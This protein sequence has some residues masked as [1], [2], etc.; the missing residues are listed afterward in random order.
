MSTGRSALMSSCGQY[1]YSLTRNWSD[2]PRVGWVLLNPSTADG[3]KDDPTVRRVI[4]F[5]H[6]WGY[7]GLV[8]ANLYAYRATK[9]AD[10]WRAQD[11]V[12]PGND[13]A[14]ARIAA[15]CDLLVAA[16]GANARP[17]R[18]AQVLALPGMGRLHALAVTATGQPRHPLYLRGDLKP[19]P[20]E[21]PNA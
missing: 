12:G 10:L 16:W 11:P 4:G 6:A 14:L 15:G 20:W 18:I 9:P 7:G 13:A 5:T 2:G 21:V 17:D 3:E 1:R 8:V 19:Q